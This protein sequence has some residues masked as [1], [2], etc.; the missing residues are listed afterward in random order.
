MN[1]FQKLGGVAALI[2]ALAYAIGFVGLLTLFTEY[3][4][5]DELDAAGRVAFVRDHLAV[6]Q[7]WHLVLYVVFGVAL[8]ILALALHERLKGGAPSMMQV[9]TAFGLLW[10]G[11]VLASG[12]ISVVGM[13][14]VS[15]LHGSDPELAAAAWQAIEIVANGIGGGVEIVGGLWLLLVSWSALRCGGLPRVLSTI[16]VVSGVAGVLTVAPPLE[17]LGAAFGLGQLVWF[18]WVGAVMLRHGQ[19]VGPSRDAQAPA[20]AD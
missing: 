13:G 19:N 14:A 5:G 8:V 18:V 20:L 10:A 4:V 11:L 12:M 9:A 3:F 1:N 2:Q 6:M 7:A 16:G 17:A 15:D